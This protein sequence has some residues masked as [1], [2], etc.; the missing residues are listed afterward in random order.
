MWDT[1]LCI[2]DQVDKFH[3]GLEVA[4][5]Q[6]EL[7]FSKY[8]LSYSFSR[9]M[10]LEIIKHDIFPQPFLAYRELVAFF[11]ASHHFLGH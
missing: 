4:F 7:E 1:S 3:Q 8:F 9:P 2:C 11:S 5:V 10:F 6:N